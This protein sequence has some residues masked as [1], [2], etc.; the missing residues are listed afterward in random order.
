MKQIVKKAFCLKCQG[1]CRFSGK[2]SIWSPRLL[3][4]EKN[5]K[6]LKLTFNKKQGSFV[7]S[8]LDIENNKCKIYSSCPFEC[9]LYPFLI[10]KKNN[11]AFLAVHLS[12]PF[13]TQN[14]KTHNLKKYTHYL[15]KLF[16]SPK[17]KNILKNNPHIIQKYNDEAL[18]IFELKI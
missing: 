8:L 14:L 13:I 3:N 7:C 15:I 6:K 2:D 11:K 4:E 18:N 17:Y 12:C 9:K 5:K 16:S 10:N 1:C